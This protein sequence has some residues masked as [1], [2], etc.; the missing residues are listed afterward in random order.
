MSWSMNRRSIARRRPGLALC[1]ALQIFAIAALV[2]LRVVATLQLRGLELN[3][4]VAVQSARVHSVRS[5]LKDSAAMRNNTDGRGETTKYLRREFGLVGSAAAVAHIRGIDVESALTAPLHVG[6][7][8][9]T[10][11]IG[12]ASMTLW[13]QARVVKRLHQRGGA[14][15]ESVLFEVQV[16]CS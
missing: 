1:L 9:L 12:D 5:A 8:V 14:R 4:G 10:R 15:A 11:H 16:S 3:D 6:D 7:A 13:L 2:A